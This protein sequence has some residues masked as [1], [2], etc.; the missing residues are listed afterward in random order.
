MDPFRS[1]VERNEP[2]DGVSPTPGQRS[3]IRVYGEAVA[4]YRRALSR[5]AETV[6]TRYERGVAFALIDD[7][8][9]A[10]HT[11]DDIPLNDTSVTQA[12]RSIERVRGHYAS[13]R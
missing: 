8:A 1:G 10:R 3:R 2:V 5:H 4:A 13:H 6:S 12:R 7:T 11:F 9:S